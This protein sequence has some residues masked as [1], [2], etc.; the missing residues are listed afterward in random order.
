MDIFVIN[1]N[2][3]IDR[4]EK[5]KIKFSLLN[6]IRIEAIEEINGVVGCF[7]SHQKCIELAKKNKLKKIL[8]FEDDCELL[9][10]ELNDFKLLLEKTNE[11]LDGLEEWK[12]LYGA[13]NKLKYSNLQKKIVDLMKINGKNYSIYSADFLKTAH[14]VW[15]NNLIYDW[16]LNLNS[17]ESGPID[18]IWHGKFNCLII[19]PFLCTQSDDYS[20]IEN[21]YCSY[22]AS[23]KRYEKR[24]LKYLNN[25]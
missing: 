1:L 10:I 3:R 17:Y 25:N 11:F 6:L 7:K 22:T 21:K 19:I 5:I 16:V 15:Y 9:N 13:G 18:K 8:V 4:W 2:K 20:D 23:L 14:F 24:L 12:I